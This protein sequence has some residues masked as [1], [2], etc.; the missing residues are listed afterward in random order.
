MARLRPDGGAKGPPPPSVGTHAGTALASSLR[1]AERER[2]DR[3]TRIVALAYVLVA[4]SHLVLL[5]PAG[6][7]VM[8]AVALGC[9]VALYG[10]VRW[11]AAGTPADA[12]DRWVVTLLYASIVGHSVVRLHYAHEP[13][14]HMFV[15]VLIV[16]LALIPGTLVTH[17]LALGG[18]MA[19]WAVIMVLHAGPQVAATYL[20]PLI[21]GL[22]LS[23]T[24]RYL[25]RARG[26]RLVELQLQSARRH[27]RLVE[28]EAERRS[29]LASL[30]HE[31]RHD[32]LTGMPNRAS[33][34]EQLERAVAGARKGE[35]P[36]ALL[37]LDLN[38]FKLVND[39]LGHDVG[40]RLLQAVS[41]RLLRFVR[42][43]DSVARFG[44]DEFAVL[45]LNLRSPGDALLVAERLHTVF[46]EPFVLGDYEVPL[47]ASIGIAPFSRDYTDANALLRDGEIAMHEAKETEQP[48]RVF[49]GEMHAKAVTRL[50]TEL[51]LR[52][53]LREDQLEVHYQPLITL[54][55]EGIAGFEAL[56][57]WRHPDRG[58]IAP[59]HF[60]PL[61]EETGLIVEFDRWVAKQACQ[62]LAGWCRR[63]RRGAPFV[64][65]NVS[66]RHFAEADFL[67]LVH[68]ALQD[69][70]LAPGQLWI[71]IIESAVMNQPALAEARIGRLRDLGVTV[72]VD[73]F[74]VGY[75]SLGYLQ[76]FAFNVMKLDRSFVTPSKRNLH[77]LDALV[78]V[79]EGLDMKVV[80]EGIEHSGQLDHIRRLGVDY[81]QGYLFA[82]PMPAAEA[83]ELLEGDLSLRP[84]PSMRH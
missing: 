78:R 3:L 67:E 1:R 20:G 40:D 26:R 22:G 33:F 34:T 2:L 83:Q 79:A 66:A 4:A 58:L 28:S 19:G 36:F 60:L 69:S 59:G 21:L 51:D 37:H 82:K 76:R 65:V 31:T 80:A 16:A 46:E 45:L 13:G 48:L 68:D 84:P 43:G 70:G 62:D 14:D 10:G 54:A 15:G 38:R 53:A 18:Y 5:P 17:V 8:I 41:E 24:I 61:A 11:L 49:D 57:R 77:L 9:A 72:A 35:R 56:V 27:A 23:I 50:H 7:P 55:D 44:G 32:S 52:R 47:S 81:G 6:R 30:E 75:S 73:D 63:H 42:P 74:G 25:E 71:E 12:R 29:A 39:S 64:S